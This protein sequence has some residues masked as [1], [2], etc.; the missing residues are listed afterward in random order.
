[1]VY[2]IM[3]V[4]THNPRYSQQTCKEVSHLREMGPIYGKLQADV[5]SAYGT[6]LRPTPSRSVFRFRGPLDQRLRYKW[7]LSENSQIS[8]TDKVIL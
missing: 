2:L 6:N 8:N 7:L 1:M 4:R 5:S 3:Q